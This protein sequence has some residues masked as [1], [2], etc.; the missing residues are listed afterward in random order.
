MVYRG[1]TVTNFNGP[2]S[3]EVGLLQAETQPSD[4]LLD[5]LGLPTTYVVTT[6]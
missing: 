6:R 1:G 5:K 2:E 4:R 3:N